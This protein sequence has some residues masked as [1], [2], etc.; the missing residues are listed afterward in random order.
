MAR[1]KPTPTRASIVWRV[2]EIKSSGRVKRYLRGSGELTLTKRRVGSILRTS[3]PST[4]GVWVAC[5]R[6]ALNSCTLRLRLIYALEGGGTQEMYLELPKT[7]LRLLG[8]RIPREAR[9]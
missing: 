2:Q 5:G 1:R 4:L 9:C 8:L 6:F 3:G 7:A